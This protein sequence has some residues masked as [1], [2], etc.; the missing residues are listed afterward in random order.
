M[1]Q[2][3]IKVDGEQR[4]ITTL[5]SLDMGNPITVGML[6]TMCKVGDKVKQ[7]SMV[8]V[9]SGDYLTGKSLGIAKKSFNDYFSDDYIE[10]D[11]DE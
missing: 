8:R 9:P 7:C 1:S 10:D 3:K 11:I 6:E 5:G 2:V 4:T